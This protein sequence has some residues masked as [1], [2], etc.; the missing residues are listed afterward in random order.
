MTAL[1]T[2][3]AGGGN[4]QLHMESW[5]PCRHSESFL[6]LTDGTGCCTHDLAGVCDSCSRVFTCAT[7]T[8]SGGMPWGIVVAIMADLLISVGLALQKVA[9]NNVERRVAESKKAGLEDTAKP[10]FTTE[11]TWWIGLALQIGS[12]VGNFAAYGDPNTPSAVVAALGCVSVISTW[13]ITAFYLKEGFRPRDLVGVLFVVVGVVT[14][15]LYVPRDPEGG[16]I[17]LLPCPIFF[18]GNFSRASCELPSFWPLGDSFSSSHASGVTVCEKHGLLAVGSIYWYLIQPW[19]LL[20][21][22]ICVVAWVTIFLYVR[23]HRSTMKS[24]TPFLALADIAGGLTVKTAAASPCA[25]SPSWPAE[26]RCHERVP[27]THERPPTV[28]TPAARRCVPP[29]RFRRFYSR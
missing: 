11:T 17:N 8:G 19:W 15:I 4:V 26:A 23:R 22:A 13:A 14:L 18:L 10:G 3:L 24:F 20:F 27:H 7:T 16:T 21:F 29:S 6:N 12:E 5:G 25:S 28:P 2:C 1:P 9:H